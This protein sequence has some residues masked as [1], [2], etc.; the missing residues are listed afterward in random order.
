MPATVDDLKAHIRH[1]CKRLRQHAPILDAEDR[2]AISDAE[3]AI[4]AFP[5]LFWGVNFTRDDLR[6]LEDEDGEFPFRNF[7]DEYFDLLARRLDKS[8]GEIMLDLWD[9]L[10][11]CARDTLETAEYEKEDAE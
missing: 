10:A 3:H 2:E 4:S 6:Y 8:L 1:L 7:P 9:I 11:D 5:D